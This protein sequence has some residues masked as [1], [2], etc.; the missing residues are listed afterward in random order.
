MALQAEEINTKVKCPPQK[1]GGGLVLRKILKKTKQNN[2][3]LPS[4]V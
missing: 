3:K 2:Q 1:K 4:S